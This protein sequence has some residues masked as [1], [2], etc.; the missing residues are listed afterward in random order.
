MAARGR[1]RAEE[2]IARLEPIFERVVSLGKPVS[3]DT[4][5][6]SVARWALVRG[7]AILN[8]VWGFQRDA[9]MA[10]SRRCVRRARRADA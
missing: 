5:K 7:A 4:M 2:E 9:E 6:A 1:S 3:I 8:D 10:R